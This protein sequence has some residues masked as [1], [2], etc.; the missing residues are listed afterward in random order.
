MLEKTCLEKKLLKLL[1]VKEGFMDV[2]F[3]LGFLS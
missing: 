1:R 2:T 3:D